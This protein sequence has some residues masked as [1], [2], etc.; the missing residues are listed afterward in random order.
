MMTYP[1]VKTFSKSQVQE[2]FTERKECR[3]SLFAERVTA[4][5]DNNNYYFCFFPSTYR[6]LEA[7]IH[8]LSY[9]RR[10]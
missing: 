10:Q 9:T 4:P 8:Q 7:R 3:K 1:N 6:I 5:T 2:E